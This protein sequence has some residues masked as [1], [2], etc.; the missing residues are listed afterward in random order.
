MIMQKNAATTA[1]IGGALTTSFGISLGSMYD[2]ANSF[3]S[4]TLANN[5]REIYKCSGHAM[6]SPQRTRAS[7]TWELVEQRTEWSLLVGPAASIGT[8]E[9]GMI[10]SFCSWCCSR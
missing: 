3:G 6:R 7:T 10:R 8:K 5:H 4:A 1:E 2:Q 9:G